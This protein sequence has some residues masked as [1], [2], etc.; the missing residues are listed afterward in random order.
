[1]DF[2]HASFE[3]IEGEIAHLLL[4]ACKIHGGGCGGAVR[5]LPLGMVK[6]PLIIEHEARGSGM[7]RVLKAGLRA[8][9]HVAEETWRSDVAL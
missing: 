8:A 3:V 4:E 2:A 6:W 9:V 5:R 7:A 1:L